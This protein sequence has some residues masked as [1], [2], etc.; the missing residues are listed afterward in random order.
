MKKN[1]VVKEISKRLG[2][3][4]VEC[5]KIIETFADVV[6]EALV[7]GENVMIKDFVSFEISERKERQGYNP[8]TGKIE[9]FEPVRTVK[10]KA[11]KSI[12]KAVK[13]V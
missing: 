4:K 10:C 12:K 2:L 8:T 13:E 1:D 6:K 11:G 7:N 9:T 5:G 3:P